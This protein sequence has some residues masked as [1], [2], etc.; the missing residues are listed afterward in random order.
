VEQR[1]QIVWQLRMGSIITP[2]GLKWLADTIRDYRCQLSHLAP[3]WTTESDRC[4]ER[5]PSAPTLFNF[6]KRT[7]TSE[8]GCAYT[9]VYEAGFR[10]A[11]EIFIL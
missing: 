11:M 9:I 6:I 4:E 5:E 10:I 2:N 1:S 8:Y 3:D 7:A